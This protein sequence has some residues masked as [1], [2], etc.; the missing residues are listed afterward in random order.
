MQTEQTQATRRPLRIVLSGVTVIALV[1]VM[2]YSG[3]VAISRILVKYGT[4]V[5]DTAAIDTAIGL[6]PS[7]AEAHY[8]RGALANYLQQPA[9][10]LK[11][12]EL[13]VS[14]R[15]HDYY[16]WLELGMT[17]DQLGDQAGAL[18]C[19]NE[20]VRLA[21]YYAQP[22]WQRGNVLFRKGSYDE[23][24]VDLRQAAASDPDF[25]PAL[26]D[27]AWGTSGKDAQVTEQMV[28]VQNGKGHYA[29]ALF[30]ARHGKADEAVSHFR[31][32]GTISAENRR[33]LINELLLSHSIAQAYDVWT[34]KSASAPPARGS[35][36][37][38]G[39]EGSLN[40]DETGF[41]WRL[42]AAQPGLS[43]SL[44]GSQ[45][46]SGARSLRIDFTGHA[47]PSYELISQLIPVEPAARYKLNFAA[48]T[49]NIVTGGPLVVVVKDAN[50]QQLL[51]H[52]P[53]LPADTNGWQIFSVE[54]ATGTAS[55]A[56]IVSLQRDDCTSS[57]CP[58][59]GSVYLDSFSL[60]R[61]K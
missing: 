9:D 13:A 46:Q 7:D 29:L 10:A 8:A 23:A 25:L 36:F 35:V 60:E 48:R 51:G 12:L 22:R 27:L 17:R 14:L 49:H 44:D 40:R 26:I 58:I 50:G 45:P 38:G 4:T 37:D 59:F 2:L 11:E 34:S 47:A 42:V 39:F 55:Q 28:Q 3:R 53:Q 19:F 1:W 15:P 6:T 52:S 20:A 16:F 41:G 61:L 31:S 54:F 33:D 57:P 32:A 30:F 56:V 21:P 24:F 5:A 18:A 43:L